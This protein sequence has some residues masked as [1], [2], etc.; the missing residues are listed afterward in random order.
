MNAI[1]EVWEGRKSLAETFWFWTITF[2]HVIFG[3][4]GVLILSE[5]IFIVLFMLLSIWIYVVLWRCA[6][7]NPG[8][9]AIWVKALMIFMFVDFIIRI[10]GQRNWNI[11]GRALSIV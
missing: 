9:W 10:I 7:N 5:G 8:Y 11:I 1:E 2:L 4:V 6:S 3:N